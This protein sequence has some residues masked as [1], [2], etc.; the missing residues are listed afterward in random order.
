MT[1]IERR[2]WCLICQWNGIFILLKLFHLSL[3]FFSTSFI[4]INNT[5]FGCFFYFILMF[6]I[7]FHN[8]TTTNHLRHHWLPWV[9][10]ELVR[11]FVI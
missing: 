7:S 5:M 10:V 6:F 11:M 9:G 1:M 8:N 2:K 4:F 3:I